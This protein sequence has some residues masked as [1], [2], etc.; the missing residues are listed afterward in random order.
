MQR[1]IFVITYQESARNK[2]TLCDNAFFLFFC[3]NKKMPNTRATF[4]CNLKM[5]I[6]IPKIDFE[7]TNDRNM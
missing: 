7:D 6:E 1:Q 2:A 4:D 3:Q 5:I